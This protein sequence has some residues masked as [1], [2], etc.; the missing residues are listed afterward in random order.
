[1][2]PGLLPGAATG[3]P[4]SFYHFQTG[5]PILFLLCGAAY[6]P[7]SILAQDRLYENPASILY[8]AQEDILKKPREAV[9]SNLWHV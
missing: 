4:R 2:A 1:M 7:F 8:W 3:G 6:S 5:L 9:W